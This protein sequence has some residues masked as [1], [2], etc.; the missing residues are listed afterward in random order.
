MSKAPGNKEKI[1]YTAVKLFAQKGYAPVTMREIAAEVGIRAASIYNHY[2]SKESLLTAM[3]EYFRNALKT[4]VFPS[5][6]ELRSLPPKEYLLGTM[7]SIERMF[8]DPVLRD[9]SSILVKEQFT[10]KT[11]R[12][13]LLTELI[14][15]PREALTEYFAFLMSGGRMRKTNPTLAAK[16]YHAYFIYRFYENSLQID[17]GAQEFYKDE[18]EQAAHL[19]LFLEHFQLEDTV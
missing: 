8:T 6:E 16:E 11:V 9:I 12:L 15:K 14:Q 10:N 2:D 4:Q 18:D 7:N 3:V 13:L 17:G 1:F 5:F 19:N